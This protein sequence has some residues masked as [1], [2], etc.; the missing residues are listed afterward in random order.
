MPQ[1]RQHVNAILRGLGYALSRSAACVAVLASEVKAVSLHH[2][3]SLLEVLVEGGYLRLHPVHQRGHSTKHSL[4]LIIP[5][6]E[7]QSIRHVL[8][9][10]LHKGRKER[11]VGY[12][13]GE[14]V[15]HIANVGGEGSCSVLSCAEGGHQRVRDSVTQRAK[16]PVQ[17]VVHRLDS[18]LV[19]LVEGKHILQ[20]LLTPLSE[21]VRLEDRLCEGNVELTAL[22]YEVG[23]EL[24]EGGVVVYAMSRPQYPLL[25]APR[26]DGDIL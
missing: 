26:L 16:Q 7:A 10:L 20:R 21:L 22:V 4:H 25:V 1:A 8:L 6:R 13:L 12:L 9:R 24:A 2:L 23:V 5:T 3:L 17:V 19:L 18:L 14:V 11:R 15:E